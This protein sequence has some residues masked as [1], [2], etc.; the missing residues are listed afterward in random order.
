MMVAKNR[1]ARGTTWKEMLDFF[2]RLF[3]GE[4]NRRRAILA[5]KRASLMV[6]SMMT[7][8]HQVDR[9]T[10]IMILQVFSMRN[11][12]CE[13]MAIDIATSLKSIDEELMGKT[14]AIG[15][16]TKIMADVDQEW[17]CR[18]PDCSRLIKST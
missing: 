6:G 11:Q 2:R 13:I 9:Q 16:A 15:M 3:P 18:Q 14:Y 17:L 5:A 1:K 7:S 8:F 12:E 10:Q 4:S